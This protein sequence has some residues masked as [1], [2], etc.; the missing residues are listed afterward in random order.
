[1]QI[2]ESILTENPC[3]TAGRKIT[4]EGLML[5]SVGCPQPNASAFVNSWNKTSFDSACVHAF[6]DATT[7]NVYQT[8]PWNHRGW[9]SGGSAN[10]THI[11]IEMCEPACIEY[12]SGSSFTCS[13]LA[14]AQDCVKRTYESAV[15]LFAY[16]C[17]KYNLNPLTDICS[18]NEGYDKG[19]ASNHGDP[20]HLWKGVGLDYT[21]SGFK[22]DVA[23]AVAGT[24][25]KAVNTT[26]NTI[27]GKGE[28]DVKV[29][30]LQNGATG[31]N[32]KA[33]QAILIG[34]GYSCGKCGADGV[35]GND[36]LSA[37]K[38]YQK[39]KKLVVDGIVG[40]KTWNSLLGV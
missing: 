21:M 11:G 39:N 40:S 15:E 25:N 22:N 30:T 34:Y 7:G 12:T 19:I 24:T 36:T 26:N 37:V 23:E 38:S 1:M 32:V 13:D 14:A 9:H 10:N 8:L 29:F 6:I 5:H 17:R 27:Q 20:E 16:L 28:I 33:L 18:H 4:V 31:S 3:Y 35:F 2:I